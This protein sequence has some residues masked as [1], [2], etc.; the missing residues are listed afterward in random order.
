MPFLPE[1]P[2]WPH[3]LIAQHCGYIVFFFRCCCLGKHTQKPKISENKK[4]S[5]NKKEN[6]AV[7]VYIYIYFKT[8]PP[9]QHCSLRPIDKS[10]CATFASA[11]VLA[12]FGDPG[13]FP[14]LPPTASS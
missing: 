2:H 8:N 3:S 5:R 4:I 12:T 11:G 14:F 7:S 9:A 13:A 6:L 10:N 1:I